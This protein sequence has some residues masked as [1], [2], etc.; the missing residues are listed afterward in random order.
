MHLFFK[1]LS[2]PNC[3]TLVTHKLNINSVIS[4]N[5]QSTVKLPRCPRIFLIAAYF[6]PGASEGLCLAFA[7]DV[8]FA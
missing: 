2:A 1:G 5:M 8:S 6:L 7:C 3:S 4:S